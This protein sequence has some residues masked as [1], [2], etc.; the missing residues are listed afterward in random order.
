MSA[1]DRFYYRD[2]HG[3]RKSG[4]KAFRGKEDRILGVGAGF[5]VRVSRLGQNGFER[6]RDGERTEKEDLGDH[7]SEKVQRVMVERVLKFLSD[8]KCWVLI[9]KLN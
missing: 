2:T 7:E 8:N 6:E 5:A 9:L 3:A 4:G 1:V